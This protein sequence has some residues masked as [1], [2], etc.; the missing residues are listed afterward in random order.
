MQTLAIALHHG[1]YDCDCCGSFGSDSATFT[2]DGKEVAYAHHDGHFGGGCWRQGEIGD[3]YLWGLALLGFAVNFTGLANGESSLMQ[4]APLWYKNGDERPEVE[5]PKPLVL[6][7][8]IGLC[9]PESW[10][11]DEAKELG[12]PAPEPRLF[13]KDELPYSDAVAGKLLEV[14]K[15]VA[16]VGIETTNYSYLDEPEEEVEEAEVEADTED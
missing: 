12:L 10:E 6:D 7:V 1:F 16:T 9:P 15:S 11:F 13:T 5:F 14:L 4:V 2:L 8:P 3:V